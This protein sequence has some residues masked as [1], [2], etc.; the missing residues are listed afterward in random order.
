MLL[1]RPSTRGRWAPAIRAGAALAISSSILLACGFGHDSLLAALGVFAALYG[2]G[3]PYRFRWKAVLTAGSLLLAAAALFGLWGSAIGPLASIPQMIGVV[4]GL[5]VFT[6][7]TVF[8]TSALRL[9]P[10]GPYFF[11]LVSGIGGLV[12]QH[13]V[14]IDHLALFVATGVVVALAMSMAAALWRPHG[15]ETAATIAAVTAAERYLAENADAAPAARHGVALSTLRAW[16]VL[17]DAAATDTELAQRLW[18]SHQK[19]HGAEVATFVVPLPRPSILRRLQSASRLGS[20]ATISALRASSAAAIAGTIAVVSGLG[21]PDWAVLGAALVLQM[22]PDRV[23]GTVR[24]VHRVAGTVV[25]VGLF[26]GLYALDLPIAAL[27]AVLTVLNVLIELTISTNYAIA[28]MLIT[29][30]SLLIG[31]PSTPLAEQVRDRVLETVLGVGVALITAWLLLPR[32][33]RRTLRDAD[34]AALAAGRHLVDDGAANPVDSPEMRVDR[35]DLQW[36]LLEAELA[37]TDSACDDPDWAR[38]YWPEHARVR[39]LGYEVLGA[40]WRTPLGLPIDAQT[41]AHLTERIG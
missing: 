33:H 21:R 37:A 14:P 13:G 12:G 17:H 32:A 41:R 24:G 10:P 39:D 5:T 38:A 11:V 40:C 31:G 22:G 20:H 19:I 9:G 36:Q 3:R 18:T 25:G 15:P 4:A 27:L 7:V 1:R 26:A 16:S 6:A 30:L 34:A 29:P 28:V 35:R 2:E 8:V 23:H